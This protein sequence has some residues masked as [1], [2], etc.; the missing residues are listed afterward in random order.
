[1]PQ[2]ASQL[3]E[4]STVQ[5]QSE[6]P[7][8]EMEMMEMAVSSVCAA[9]EGLHMEKELMANFVEAFSVDNA[10]TG[11]VSAKK[12]SSNTSADVAIEVLDL[13]LPISCS[14]TPMTYCCAA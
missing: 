3:F 14:P 4:H 7:S 8:I 2:E 9:F 10:E 11:D 13:V 12:E 1:M 6:V 5:A